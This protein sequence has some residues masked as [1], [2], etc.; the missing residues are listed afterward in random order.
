MPNS[1]AARRIKEA[2]LELL[3]K[4][5]H[6]PIT[7]TEIARRANVNR[8]TFYRLYETHEAVLEDIL[9]DFSQ[10]NAPLLA[11]IDP[12]GAGNEGAVHQ[13]LEHHRANM[14]MLRTVLRSDMAHV[15]VARVEGPITMSIESKDP[16]MVSFY[17][18]GITRVICDWILGGC[19]ESIDDL[20][21]FLKVVSGLT[22]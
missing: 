8:V 15:L 18:A 11:T 16:M 20:I 3:E 17:R 14:P 21:A 13:M 9:D 12:T 19:A 22:A 7:V 1:P 5:P 10:K 6:G 4:H 2:Y